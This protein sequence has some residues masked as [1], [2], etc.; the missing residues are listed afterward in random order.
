M[1]L[2]FGIMASTPPPVDEGIMVNFGDSETGFGMEEPAPGDP[3]PAPD[4]VESA[5]PKQIV[6][7]PSN[8]NVPPVDDDDV[9]TQDD[10]ETV[11]VK[12]PVKKKEI[13]K[14][15]DPEK[16]R[17]DEAARI[18][19]AEDLRIKREQEQLL[20]QAAAEE[21]KIGEINKRAKNVFGGGG[22]GSPDSKST[23][24][25]VTYGPGNQGSPGGVANSDN[26]GPGGGTGD[27]GV[28]FSLDGRTAQSLP[29]PEFLGNED[30]KVVVMVTVDKSGRVT[31]ADAG[32]KG[33]NTTNPELLAAAKKA[34]L[35]ARF[36]VDG[37]AS[38]FQTGTITY[39]F[40][41]N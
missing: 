31:K 19:K 20:A 40:V 37:T 4:P 24:Q 6:Q 30:G 18:K 9:L 36:N 29:K 3:Q 35:E 33:S 27:S 2:Y 5:S 21:R 1:L 26:Y 13:K 7:P 15:V 14:V 38:S 17:L 34:A 41:L 25:G 16:Q 28:S 10:E 23:S 39:R 11:A 32:V 22:K 12:T 8:K